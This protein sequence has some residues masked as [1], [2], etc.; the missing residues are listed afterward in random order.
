MIE[1]MNGHDHRTGHKNRRHKRRGVEKIH[2]QLAQEFGQFTLFSQADPLRIGGDQLNVL[3]P[4][5]I[6]KGGTPVHEYKKLM[7]GQSVF[8]SVQKL[9]NITCDAV[10]AALFDHSGIDCNPQVFL[11]YSQ[12]QKSSEPP[13]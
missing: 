12:W 9:K 4:F 6:K 3:R 11:L 5:F 2:P 10:H 8:Q 7:P 1:V 13:T